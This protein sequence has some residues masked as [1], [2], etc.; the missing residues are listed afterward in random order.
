MGPQP[1]LVNVN[2]TSSEWLEDDYC[3]SQGLVINTTTT[4]LKGEFLDNMMM[5]SIDLS[6]VDSHQNGVDIDSTNIGKDTWKPE[7]NAL[8][9][10]GTLSIVEVCVSGFVP[11]RHKLKEMKDIAYVVE[12]TWSDGR[13]HMVKRTF[14][15]FY[16]F[17]CYLLDEWRSVKYKDG[18]VKLTLYLPGWYRSIVSQW[19]E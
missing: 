15:D 16:N 7:Q 11:I 8:I 3:M 6:D 9:S 18:P 1:E 10:H 14:T 2:D 12:V 5:T 13:T 4:V 19:E 17:H